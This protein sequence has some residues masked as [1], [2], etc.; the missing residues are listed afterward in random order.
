MEKMTRKREIEF[1]EQSLLWP[2]HPI[3]PVVLRDG[4]FNDPFF[5]GFLFSFSCDPLP[6]VYYANVF[7]LDR[8]RDKAREISGREKVTWGEVLDQLDRRAY[9]SFDS[10][11]DVYR[12][13]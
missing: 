13:D 10:L 3:L 4:D 2:K 11:L 8:A 9:A 12:I 1:I 6:V 7:G 5:A